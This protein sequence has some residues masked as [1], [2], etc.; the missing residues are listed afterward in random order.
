MVGTD[1]I[2]APSEAAG[3]ETAQDTRSP[4]P[5]CA[6]CAHAARVSVLTGYRKGE[7]QIEHFCLE[8]VDTA[9]R[10]L[11]D[12]SLD[13]RVSS[14]LPL[15]FFGALC[16]LLAFISDHVPGFAGEHPGVGSL[17]MLGLVLGVTALV[18]GAMLRIDPVAMSGAIVVALAISADFMTLGR[19][20]GLGWK[21]GVLI[22]A[23]CGV[24][25]LGVLRQLGHAS[26]SRRGARP[27]MLKLHE[28]HT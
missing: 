8:C 16:G 27:A 2:A 19:A 6:R 18:L 25:L 12:R 23:S 17:Q 26:L 1:E 10:T 15:V 11:S 20:P 3:L 7:P 13:E 22:A 21:Q 4:R 5:R 14:G 28:S 24:M 9:R